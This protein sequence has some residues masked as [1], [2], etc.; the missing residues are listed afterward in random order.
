MKNSGVILLIFILSSI[1]TN[2]QDNLVC[3]N[4]SCFKPEGKSKSIIV[5]DTSTH[6]APNNLSSAYSINNISESEES[7]NYLSSP[8][9]S[10]DSETS[11]YFTL[12][13]KN[14]PFFEKR[15]MNVPSHDMDYGTNPEFESTRPKLGLNIFHKKTWPCAKTRWE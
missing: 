5:A 4:T 8:R 7:E 12:V 13:N 11:K 6:K 14:M 10:Q 3:L 15:F 1:M 2:A 9:Y